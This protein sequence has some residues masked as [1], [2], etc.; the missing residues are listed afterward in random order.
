M[1]YLLACIGK[2]V[3]WTCF[4]AVDLT[5]TDSR[6]ITIIQQRRAQLVLGSWMGDHLGTPRVVEIHFCSSFS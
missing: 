6:P 4:V 3:E 5:C 1:I 2:S